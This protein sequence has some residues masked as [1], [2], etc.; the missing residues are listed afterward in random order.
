VSILTSRVILVLSLS[1]GQLHA[2]AS[3]DVT[4]FG[5]LQVLSDQEQRQRVTMYL[6]AG[7]LQFLIIARN[8]FLARSNCARIVEQRR[9]SDR[10]QEFQPMIDRRLA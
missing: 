3:T 6:D 1:V 2:V 8:C 10:R 5:Q 4:V 9:T 7:L